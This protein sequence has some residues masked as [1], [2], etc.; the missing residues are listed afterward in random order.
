[1]FC[2]PAVYRAE[3]ILSIVCLSLAPCPLA[4]QFSTLPTEI[5][6][7]Y[8]RIGCIMCQLFTWFLT[9]ARNQSHQR[10]PRHV[11][12]KGSQFDFPSSMME[13]AV[14]FE[15]NKD[16]GRAVFLFTHR[17]ISSKK[18]SLFHYSGALKKGITQDPFVL[19][20]TLEH[21]LFQ[22]FRYQGTVGRNGAFSLRCP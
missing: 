9:P 14:I 4:V 8:V 13:Q 7:P 1:M 12:K 6:R 3:E 20:L 5:G 21:N 15:R 17:I 19:L 16:N 2:N 10:L 18:F 22:E 11:D